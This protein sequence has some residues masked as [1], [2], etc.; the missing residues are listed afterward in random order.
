MDNDCI[1]IA[2]SF[3]NELER[4]IDEKEDAEE[5]AMLFPITL[6]FMI[7]KF[8]EQHTNKNYRKKAQ[9]SFIEGI[10]DALKGYANKHWSPTPKKGTH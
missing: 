8:I 3:L 7:T 1:E 2:N 5:A 10:T 6:C 9:D 4:I